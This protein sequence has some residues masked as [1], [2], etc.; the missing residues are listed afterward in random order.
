MKYC[1]QCHT[2]ISDKL[3]HDRR[4]KFCSHKCY[5]D[6][7]IGNKN[8]WG[9]K[10][11]KKLKGKPKTP[12]HILAVVTANTGK[13]HYK[14]RDERHFA[15]K[16]DK[17]GYDGL[18]DWVKLRKDRKKECEFCGEPDKKTRRIDGVLRW[19]LQLANKSGE[20]KRDLRDWLWLCPK[21]HWHYD[22]GKNS[23][24]KVFSKDSGRKPPSRYIYD[25]RGSF[26]DWTC[27]TKGLYRNQL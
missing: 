13:I 5:T 21:C 10:I 14:M 7:L 2:K 18:H 27:Y 15:W 19:H 9:Y 1:L 25:S 3:A 24:H 22:Y 17:C 12:K 6:S 4:K 23:V 26:R 16:G 8:D 11:S 20:Y